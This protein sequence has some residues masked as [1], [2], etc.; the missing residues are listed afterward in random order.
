MQ[1]SIGRSPL[2][3][4]IGL[5]WALAG[6]VGPTMAAS[7]PDVGLYRVFEAS[8]ENHEP[9]E[10]KFVDVELRCTYTAPSG[11]EIDFIG[12]ECKAGDLYACQS[13]EGSFQRSTYGAVLDLELS[14]RSEKGNTSTEVEA[15]EFLGGSADQF[16]FAGSG[17]PCYTRDRTQCLYPN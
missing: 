6:P 3:A 16:I 9:Y 13:I 12:F 4:P 14:V 11:R 10:N 8:L 7:P 2:I 15:A 1:C 5:A 17:F